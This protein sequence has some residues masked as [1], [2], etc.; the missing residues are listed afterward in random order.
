MKE[1]PGATLR[2]ILAQVLVWSF[3]ICFYLFALLGGFSW[4]MWIIKKLL[5]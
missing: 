2:L 5:D 4:P 1:R 3:A